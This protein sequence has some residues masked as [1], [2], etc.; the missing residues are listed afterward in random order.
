[1]LKIALI[2]PLLALN[3]AAA[4]PFHDISE[5]TVREIVDAP[6]VSDPFLANDCSDMSRDAS[7]MT[8]IGWDQIIN[9]GEKVWKIIEAGK[10]IVHVKTPV[11]H[12]LPRGLKCWAD[13]GGW[14]APRTKTLEASYKNGFGMEVVK[15]RFRLHYTYGGGRLEKGRYLSNVTVLPA[16]LN[17][18]WGYNFDA[19]VEVAQAINMGTQDDPLAG[20]EL[21]VRWTV[22][23]VVKESRNSLH[24][25]VQGDGGMKLAN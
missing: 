23:T 11:A 7:P 15:F 3:T 13:L 9:I 16:E 20:L 22:K 14:Q 4:S 24:F 21:N 17:V 1:M 8:E 5:V 19:D 6:P 12:A 10:P 2:A 18:M 25:F